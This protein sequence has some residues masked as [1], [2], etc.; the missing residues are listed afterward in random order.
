MEEASLEIMDDP[1]FKNFI[2]TK[3]LSES[4]E[5]VYSGRLRAFFEF[6]GKNPS[7]FIKEAQIENKKINKYFQEYIENLKKDGKSSNTIVN[8]MDTVKA[9]YKEY[10]IDTEGINRIISPI[11]D[12]YL[13]TNNIISHDQIQ[14]ALELSSLRD[15]AII[16]F[17][18]SSGIEANELRHLTYG[19][20]LNSIKEYMDLKPEE[21]FNIKKIEDKLNKKDQIVGIWKIEKNRTKRPYVTFNTPESTWAI[22]SYLIDRERKN[23]PI[24]SLEGPLFVNSQNQALNV[25]AHGSIFKRINNRANFGYITKKRRFFSSTMLR[26]YFKTKLFE[27]EVDEKTIKAIL[28]QELNTDINYH[29]D[30]KIKELKTKYLEIVKN[31]SIERVNIETVTSEEYNKLIKQLNEKD[32]ELEE[33]KKQLNHIK[34]IIE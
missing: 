22:L 2:K 24:K 12:I 33:I 16:L 7:E 13:T 9:F 21:V 23:K 29:S 32:K 15:K 26:K 3:N 34:Q 10:D 4:S 17:H 1:Y 25:S 27:S 14:E 31:L 11:T 28:G 19:D 20:F 18:M 5:R 30:E 6:I 8:R